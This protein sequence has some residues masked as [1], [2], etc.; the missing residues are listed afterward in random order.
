[1]SDNSSE[2]T[3]LSLFVAY[4]SVSCEESKCRITELF[5][6]VLNDFLNNI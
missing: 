5:L 1:M 4:V 2:V 6:V 3:T